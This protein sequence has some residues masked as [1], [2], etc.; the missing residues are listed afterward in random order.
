MPLSNFHVPPSTSTVNVRVIDSTSQVGCSIEGMVSHT[1]KGHTWLQCPAYVFLVE[2][3]SSGRKLL[4]DLGVRKDFKNLAPPIQQ[5]FK[6]SGTTC[7]VDKDVREILEEGGIQAVE[8]EGIIWSHWHWDHIGDPSRFPKSTALIV[9]PGF[10]KILTPGYPTNP[11]APLLDSD[12]AGRELREL[13]FAESAIRVGSFPAIDYFGDGS[14][15]ILDAPGHTVGHVNA[16]ARVTTNPDS[17]ILMGADTCHHSAEMRPS[18]YHPLP[19]E[20]SPH[21]F[22]WGSQMPCPGALFKPILRDEDTTKPFYGVH[23]PGMLFG[24]PDAAEETVD[25]IIEAD[26]SGNTLV[27]IAHDSHLKDV[28]KTFPEYANDFLRQGWAQQSR[29]SFLSDFK[30]AVGVGQNEES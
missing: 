28:M 16:L 22:L 4:F 11:G 13:S 9:G 10:K 23:R 1:I 19:G 30:D 17:F 20:I 25:R 24:D 15:Y 7:S 12:F 18:K 2:H 14:F 27:V 29:W 21:P 6:E 26:G 8:L 5:W 3:P